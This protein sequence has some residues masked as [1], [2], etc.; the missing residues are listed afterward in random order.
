MAVQDL[1]G[2]APSPGDSKAGDGGVLASE[3]LSPLL[4][5]DFQEEAHRSPTSQPRDYSF[6]PK[7]GDG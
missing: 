3:G 1:E 2:L 4:G 5:M 6:D 7:D